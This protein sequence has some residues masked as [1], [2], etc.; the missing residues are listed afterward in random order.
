MGYTV[1]MGLEEKVKENKTRNKFSVDNEVGTLKKVALFGPPGIESYL[2]Q[3]WPKEKSLFFDSFDVEK[4]QEEFSDLVKILESL[5][6]EVVDLKMAYALTLSEPN[7]SA[8]QLIKKLNKKVPGSDPRVLERLLDT[9]IRVYGESHAVALNIALSYTPEVPMGNIYFARDQSN[10]LLDTCVLG[11]MKEDIRKPEVDIVYKALKSLG[12]TQ[13]LRVKK[14]TFEGGDGMIIDGKAY[15]GSG[16]R[17][18]PEAVKEIADYLRIPTYMVKIPKNGNHQEDMEIM[19]LDTFFMPL[20]DSKVIGC[21]NIL[22]RCMIYDFQSGKREN[23]LSYLEGKFEVLDM[24]PEEQK[25]YAANMLVVK[26]G[27]VIVPSD[28]NLQTTKTLMDNGIVVV[29]AGL[30]ELTRGFGA[31][32]CMTL[33]LEKYKACSN[34]NL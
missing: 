21:K 5:Q 10:V 29:N 20:T 12:Y 17:T 8:R 4:C 25:K 2:A 6:V 27:K 15:I 32:H 18:S 11:N 26:P 9:D 7:L 24:P 1:K 14:G 19:H 13:F 3:F 33:Q 16:T 22:R 28:Y 34:Q 30:Y 23:F 31:T